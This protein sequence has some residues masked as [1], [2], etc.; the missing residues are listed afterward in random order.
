MG[1]K[2]IDIRLHGVKCFKKDI[3]DNLDRLRITEKKVYD[4]SE[5]EISSETILI[6]LAKMLLDCVAVELN[7]DIVESTEGAHVPTLRRLSRSFLETVAAIPVSLLLSLNSRELLWSVSN[8]ITDIEESLFL[9][10]RSG[11]AI[12]SNGGTLMSSNA[13]EMM[14]VAIV[15]GHKNDD[16]VGSENGTDLPLLSTNES[17]LRGG[18]RFE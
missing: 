18:R 3:Y 4:A 6:G 17:S 14:A 10:G 16:P 11:T 5:Y 2:L 15:M 1:S 13:V 9:T 8:K 7:R 12:E